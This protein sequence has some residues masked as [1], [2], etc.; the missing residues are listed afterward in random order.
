M[1]A[2][3]GDR[4]CTPGIQSNLSKCLTIVEESSGVTGRRRL[5]IDGRGVQPLPSPI[6]EYAEKKK[7]TANI[8]GLVASLD[9]AS[10]K[11]SLHIEILSC[12]T[13]IIND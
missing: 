5:S 11:S 10:S 7:A 2:N 3:S 9:T 12:A 1:V 13:A 8:F 6:A 4:Y